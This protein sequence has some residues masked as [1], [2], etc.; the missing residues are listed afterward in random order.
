MLT[1]SRKV[2]ANQTRA[3]V[4]HKDLPIGEIATVTGYSVSSGGFRNALTRLR[5]RQLA[6]LT[7]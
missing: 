3:A 1:T 7:D 6:V 5:T 4:L 2:P